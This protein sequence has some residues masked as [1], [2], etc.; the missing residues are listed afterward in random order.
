MGDPATN[1][2]ARQ[3]PAE[4]VGPYRTGEEF[5]EV[6][7]LAVGEFYR[8]NLRRYENGR[9]VALSP[10]GYDSVTV[11]N[12]SG[13]ALA[14]R[15]NDGAGSYTVPG[16]VTKSFGITGTYSVEVENIGTDA[17]SN[18]GEAIIELQKEPL[19]ADEKARRDARQSTLGS[20]VENFTGLPVGKR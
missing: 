3:S 12:N 10:A 15:V 16:N 20:V 14:I 8:L 18:P 5:D 17:L 7:A 4:G 11:V 9:Y 2:S 6:P 1:F 19:G 13:Q